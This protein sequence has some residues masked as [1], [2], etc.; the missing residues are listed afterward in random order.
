[1]AHKVVLIPGDGIGPEITEAALDVLAATGV[2][3][4]WVLEEEAGMRSIEAGGEPLPEKVINSIKAHKVALK[5]PIT[6]PVGGGFKS[7]NVSLRQALDLYA[8]V[9]PSYSLPGIKTAFQ[10]VDMVL[11][12]ENTEGLYIGEEKYDAE[13]GVAEAIA[14]VTKKGSERII[15]YAFEYAKFN[16]RGKVSLVHKANILKKTSGL[17]LELGREIAKEYPQIRFEE[18]IVDNMCMQMVT[19]PERYDCIVTTNLFG[20]ILSDLA[21]GLVGGLGIV[22]GAN[23]GSEYAVFESVHGSAPDIAGQ[24]KAN[25]TALIRSAE[26]M[27]RHLGEHFAA[28]A[29][30]KSL[31]E[32]FRRGEFR[33]AD[34]GGSTPTNE[35]GKRVAEKVAKNIAK[36]RWRTQV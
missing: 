31:F 15:R 36:P 14:R 32:I 26:M 25:P 18:V 7:V 3:I 29:L 21:A 8:N 9:R 23:I 17:F 30:R 35:F 24:N 4:T 10:H 16:E 1:M 34:L 28:D 19:N 5:G 27:L 13:T 12:R 20:D 11:F 6:T 33:T 22:P 2:P